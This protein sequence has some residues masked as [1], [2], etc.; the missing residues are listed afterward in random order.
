MCHTLNLECVNKYRELEMKKTIKTIIDKYAPALRDE[1]NKRY[2]VTHQFLGAQQESKWLE[3]FGAALDQKEFQDVKDAIKKISLGITSNFTGLEY[4]I[5]LSV[6]SF[7]FLFDALNR[8]SKSAGQRIYVYGPSGDWQDTSKF[9]FKAWIQKPSPSGAVELAFV[10][11]DHRLRS[12]FSVNLWQQKHGYVE[13]L[14]PSA[15]VKRMSSQVALASDFRTESTDREC[16]AIDVVYTWV[17]S[18]DLSWR[19]SIGKFREL[20]QLDADRFS[21]QDELLFSIRS[22]EL[23]APWVRHIYIF[24]NCSPPEWF[25]PSERIRWVK[26]EEIIPPE[27]LPLFNSHAIETFLHLMPGLSEHFLYFNDDFFLSGFVDPADFFTAYG[28]SICR[29]EPYGALPF[30]HQL[31]L[32]GNAEEWHCAALNGAELIYKMFG[33]R[34]TK[35]HRHA[36]YAITKSLYADIVKTFPSELHRTREARFRQISDIS[37]ASFLY[38]HFGLAKH[39]VVESNEES[40][41]IRP[42]NF[43]KF[44]AQKTYSKVRFFC[45]ND[46][47]GSSNH[48][49]YTDFKNSFL[50]GH[51]R[52]KSAAEN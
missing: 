17:N 47:G 4:E 34:P 1:L 7:P 9:R 36:P 38:H 25:Q 12:R 48:K 23:Y 3:V 14:N 30:F 32:E 37:V 26:H 15:P 22:V 41:I 42:T 31:R 35:V 2:P 33:R 20:D 6:V 39:L 16:A 13:N 29:L 11:S 10:D 8:I 49:E 18:S 45:L 24:S 46:G 21:Q 51:Y 44:L 28:Q 27:Y 5:D 52:F 43:S 50:P 40:M 19:E